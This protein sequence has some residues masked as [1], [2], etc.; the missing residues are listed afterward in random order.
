MIIFDKPMAAE[1]LQSYR[2]KKHNGGYVMIGA[3][4]DFDALTQAKLSLTIAEC[5]CFEGITLK[6]MQK[7][8]GNAY[9]NCSA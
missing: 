8:N 5:D 7:W 2:Y 9:V 6:N 4:N 1:G 3:E